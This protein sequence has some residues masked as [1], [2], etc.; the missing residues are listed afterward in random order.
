MIRTL[1]KR[2]NG[3]LNSSVYG[4]RPKQGLSKSFLTISDDIQSKLTQG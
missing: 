1:E 2:L 3:V 4:I